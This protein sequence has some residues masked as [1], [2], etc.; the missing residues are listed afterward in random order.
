[1]N[2]IACSRQ[3]LYLSSFP[4]HHSP[5]AFV[6]Q[7]SLVQLSPSRQRLASL[8]LLLWLQSS[9]VLWSPASQCQKTENI[10]WTSCLYSSSCSWLWLWLFIFCCYSYCFFLFPLPSLT[11]VLF[12][13]SWANFFAVFKFYTKIKIKLCFFLRFN[14]WLLFDDV[15][16]CAINFGFSVMGCWLQRRWRGRWIYQSYGCAFNHSAR[17]RGLYQYNCNSFIDRFAATI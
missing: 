10:S 1:M 16:Y 11:R 15:Y 4:F 3:F 6:V 8:L 13:C 5:H 2:K 12:L 9:I 7:F 14:F 17:D